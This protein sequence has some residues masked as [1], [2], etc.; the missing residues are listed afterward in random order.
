MPMVAACTLVGWVAYKIPATM[1]I[2][3]GLWAPA[4]SGQSRA[5]ARVRRQ[6]AAAQAPWI[7]LP[8]AIIETSGSA[9]IGQI[10]RQNTHN[11]LEKPVSQSPG[12]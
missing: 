11:G 2:T 4:C 5:S 3:C 6:V 9:N 10:A 1:P 7:T 12:L 8:S